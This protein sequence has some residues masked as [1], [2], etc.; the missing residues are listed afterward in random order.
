M[1]IARVFLGWDRPCLPQAAEW[2]LARYGGPRECDLR[3]V[4]V[5]TPGSRSGERLLEL[6]VER[7]GRRL[8]VPPRILTPGDLPEHLYRANPPVADELRS[9]STRL[10]T[11]QQA[12]AELLKAI[13]VH[14]PEPED[15]AGWLDLAG[16]LDELARALA[17]KA[18]GST[19]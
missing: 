8:L 11:L 14:P 1:A 5:V 3:D 12:D 16:D 15:L 19:R 17:G 10:Y 7:A 13:V 9:L 6:L 18:C 4:F 2:L